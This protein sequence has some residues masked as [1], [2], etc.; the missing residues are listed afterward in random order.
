MHTTTAKEQNPEE[1]NYTGTDI[2][3]TQR[4]AVVR[5][6]TTTSNMCL[7]VLGQMKGSFK[8]AMRH[9]RWFVLT[10]TPPGLKK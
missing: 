9:D 8:G 5:H 6:K 3:A 4:D 1:Q 2:Q 7:S 10:L